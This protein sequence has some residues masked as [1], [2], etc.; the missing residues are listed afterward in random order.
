MG[1]GSVLCH[2]PRPNPRSSQLVSTD[3]SE[4]ASVIDLNISYLV[5]PETE[6]HTARE[7]GYARERRKETLRFAIR[8]GGDGSR[9]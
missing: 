4:W 8:G 6:H 5:N 7:V 1:I 2:S 9:W 3:F